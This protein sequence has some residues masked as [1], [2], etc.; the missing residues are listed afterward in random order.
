MAVAKRKVAT[1][2]VVVGVAALLI[3]QFLSNTRLRDENRALSEQVAQLNQLRADSDQTAKPQPA[4]T[5]ALT[6][7]QLRELLRL[8]GEVGMLR[9]GLAEQTARKARETN[10]QPS[11][12]QNQS[13][14][15]DPQTQFA[16]ARLN[17][18]KH[19]MMAFSLYADE[20]QGQ[21]PRSFEQAA[22]FL[23]DEAKSETHLTPDQ[24]EITYQG[25]FL[26]LTNRAKIIV[27]RQKEAWQSPN[28]G[29]CRVYGFAD[30]HSEVHRAAD[31]NFGPWEEQHTCLPKGQ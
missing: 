25:S 6:D 17:Y 24:F 8:R 22:S 18:A 10:L 21:C 29:W 15:V 30:G 28:A 4:S 9:N 5:P 14:P 3:S 31:G 11:Q 1:S 16:L 2:L 12:P 19:W 23:P 13:E 27:I 20:H 7:D 26:D